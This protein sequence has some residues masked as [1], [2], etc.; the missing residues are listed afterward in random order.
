MARI[1]L[2]GNE[3]EEY[4]DWS[5]GRLANDQTPV[6][7]SWTA[8]SPGGEAQDYQ[9][10]Y[11]GET[12][13]PITAS[14]DQ[15]P[16][17]VQRPPGPPDLAGAAESIGKAIGHPYV[18]HPSAVVRGTPGDHVSF[19]QLWLASGGRTPADLAAFIAAH[20]E[21][22]ATIGGSKGDK[23]TIGGRTFDAVIAAGEGGRGASWS[24]ITGGGPP[25]AG[26]EGGGAAPSAW[27]E[28]P[29][30]GQ[31]ADWWRSLMGAAPTAAAPAPSVA[32]NTP[33]FTDPATKEWESLLRSLVDRLNTP[34]QTQDYS[35]VTDYLRQY[36]EQL[37]KPGYTPAESE[38]IQT[39]T[40]DPLSQQRDAQQQQIIERFA[41]H[42][43][44]PSS[45]IVQKALQD[46][47]TQFQQLRTRAQ[48]AF[49]TNAI[50]MNQQ[51]QQQAG[52]VGLTLQ[53][54]EQAVAANDEQRA[55]HAVQQFF[56]LP[57]LADTRMAAANNVLQGSAVSPVSL[58]GALNA[59]QATGNQQNQF[60]QAQ[61]NAYLQELIRAV[62]QL[63]G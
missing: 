59:F 36:M 8:G 10:F 32:V 53:Q 7:N 12:R 62:T 18:Q 17:F 42:G 6:V 1:D 49:T 50:T 60:Q 39:Q 11:R 52:Q 29:S 30:A 3:D 20:P 13:G 43:I 46:L 41:R 55:Q 2:A 28:M 21:F 23:V 9:D 25:N 24:D 5:R 40:L 14:N 63:F 4:L 35:K 34:Q 15:S 61:T 51:R 22:G 47:D 56:Q 26:G 19:G 45:G 31:A 44:T 54:L 48:G 58:L 38:Q 27:G 37:Q 57:Q 33:V 16:P